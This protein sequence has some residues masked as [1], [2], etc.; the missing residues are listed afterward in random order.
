MRL[1]R[2]CVEIGAFRH[3]LARLGNGSVIAAGGVGSVYH[4]FNALSTVEIYGI[5]D[6]GLIDFE[7]PYC[8]AACVGAIQP[9]TRRMICSS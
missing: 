4:T 5:I 3:T 2:R 8:F 7:S 9:L 1:W 6:L